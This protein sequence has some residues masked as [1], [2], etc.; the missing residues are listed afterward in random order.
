[1]NTLPKFNNME[2]GIAPSLELSKKLKEIGVP[3]QSIFY[4]Q[5]DHAPEEWSI[6]NNVDYER[7]GITDED[8]DKK[9]S[10]F[11][12]PELIHLLGK[13]FGVLE[14]FHDGKFGAYIPHDIAVHG[15][16]ET[17]TEALGNLLLR[18]WGLTDEELK[19]EE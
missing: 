18:T 6:W 2:D 5:Y 13:R 19:G 12:I 14:R 7:Y 11:T 3:Q 10:A 15:I 9:I 4:W 8:K 1:M 17:P 16:G